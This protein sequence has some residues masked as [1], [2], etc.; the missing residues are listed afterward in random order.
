MD[1]QPSVYGGS[2]ASW[3][4][5]QRLIRQ[6]WTS[7][8]SLDPAAYQR[9]LSEPHWAT[10]EWEGVPRVAQGVKDRVGRLKALGNGIVPLCVSRFLVGLEGTE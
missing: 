2:I 8:E 4:R 6:G 10:G 1:G 5:C 7:L 3:I 9:W